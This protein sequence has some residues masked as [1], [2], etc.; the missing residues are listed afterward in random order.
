[1]PIQSG[2]MPHHSHP[3][4]MPV[5]ISSLTSLSHYATDSIPATNSSIMIVWEGKGQLTIDGELYSLKSGSIITFDVASD[6]KLETELQLQGVWIEYATMSKRKQEDFFLNGSSSLHHATTQLMTLSGELYSAWINPD[7]RKPFKVQQLF[8]QFIVDLHHELATAKET[9]GSWLEYV[10]EYIEAHYNED[11]TREQMAKLAR[12]SPEHFSRTFRKI[13]GQT[14]SAYITLLRIRRA[15][16]RILTSSPNLTTLAHEV[17]YEEGTYLSRKFK[18]LVGLSPTA[19]QNKNKKIVA[20][21]YNHTAILRVLEIMPQLGVYSDWQ[22]SLEQVPASKVLTMSE[23]NS[24]LLFDS[25]ASAEPDVIIGYNIPENKILTPVA[26]VI[27]LPFMQMSWREQ[28]GLIAHVV[29]RRQRAEEWLS[30]YDRLCHVANKQLNHSIGS[31]RG[32]AIVWELSSRAAYCFS[33]SYGRGCQIL[34]G[35]LGFKPPSIIM[36]NGI[37]DSGYLVSSIEEIGSYPADYIIITSIPSSSEG[38]Q[39]LS[40]LLRSRDWKQLDAV[41]N[42]RVYVLNKGDM[43]YGFDPLSSQA[44]LQ[45]LLRVMTS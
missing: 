38:R 33:S 6:L 15:Q 43:F 30:H 21:N 4:Y 14:F 5:M 27:E 39:R 26:P 40:R 8:A 18:Q 37:M 32:T 28:F 2:G 11:I 24:S 20:L 44:Q 41:R 23:G 19:Y 45:E 25:I 42:N 10:F 36:E 22:R 7:N 17:G 31:E 1:M 16:Q 9:S 3:F 12:V 35:D 34:Y 29:N 13:M